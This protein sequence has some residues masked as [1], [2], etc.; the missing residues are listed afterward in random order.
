[1]INPDQELRPE[2]IANI[3]LAGLRGIR[4]SFI[5]NDE[6]QKDPRQC[7]E[8]LNDAELLGLACADYTLNANKN[9]LEQK[10]RWHNRVNVLSK[11]TI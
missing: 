9:P 1:M 3:T 7:Q 10:A 8:A 11:N 5:K 6:A 4:D 2:Q